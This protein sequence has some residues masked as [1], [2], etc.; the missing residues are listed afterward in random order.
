MHAIDF[1]SILYNSFNDKSIKDT[2]SK[3]NKAFKLDYQLMLKKNNI[4]TY[5]EF[6]H[7]CIKT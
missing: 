5:N 2:E 6:F 3:Y 4:Y 7:F 1:F